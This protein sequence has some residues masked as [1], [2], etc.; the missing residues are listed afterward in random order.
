MFRA[1]A[2]KVKV[3]TKIIA[4]LSEISTNVEADAGTD[5]GAKLMTPF[6]V[7]RQVGERVLAAE[8]TLGTETAVRRFSPDDVKDMI[9]THSSSSFNL[10]DDVP[11]AITDGFG[12]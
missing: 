11:T 1:I 6:G 7:R 8:K 9:D 5:D 2:R 12:R 3:A 4:G 10:H